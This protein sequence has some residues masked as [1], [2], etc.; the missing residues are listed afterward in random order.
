[1]TKLEDQLSKLSIQTGK[2]SKLEE[3]VKKTKDALDACKSSGKTVYSS[4]D[5]KLEKNSGRPAKM[6][7]ILL[8]MNGLKLQIIT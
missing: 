7:Q 3:E 8:L 6:I 1:M 5:K 2:A 4:K